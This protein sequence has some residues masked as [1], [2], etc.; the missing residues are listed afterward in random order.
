[1][2]DKESGYGITRSLVERIK[3]ALEMNLK[4]QV[5]KVFSSL[6]PADQAELIYSLDKD[7]REKLIEILGEKT[8]PLLLVELEGNVRREIINYLDKD[9]LIN[10]LAK[11]DTDE[12]VEVLEDCEEDL[13]KEAIDAIKSSEK[14]EDIEEALSYPEDSVGRIM[15]QSSFIAVPKDW[16][17]NE[18]IKY[19]RKNKNVPQEFGNI[20]VV[21]E[22]FRPVSMASIGS[23]LKADGKTL[24]FEIM[25]NPEDLKMVNADVDQSEAA[26]LFIKYDLK[27]VPVVNHNGILVGILNSNDIIHVINEE[28]KEDMMLMAN[29]DSDDTIHASV[30]NSTKKRLPWLLGSIIT[31]SMSMLVINYFAPTIQQFIILSAIMPLAANLSGVSGTQTLSIL[32]RNISGNEIGK[33]GASKIILKQMSVGLLDGIC[34][35]LIAATVLFFWK[36][37]IKLSLIFG[38]AIVVLQILSCLIGTSVPIIIKKL[39]LDPAVGSG[40]FITALLDTT[41]SLLLLGMATLFL[42]DA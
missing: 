34:L 14:R 24:I 32:I 35:S 11:L 18:V 31:G 38:S 3:N 25:K 22:Y 5:R 2:L 1:M 39:K 26:N 6:H 41:T 40:T 23:I 27:F 13:T 20:V 4:T 12:A 33:V 15:N 28:T 29:V 16:D 30:W 37:N 42:V 21:D 10:L 36:H 8:E 9:I 19:L 17:V 7:E